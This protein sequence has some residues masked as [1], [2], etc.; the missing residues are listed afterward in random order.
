VVSKAG[1][2]I[3][4]PLPEIVDKIPA[5]DQKNIFQIFSDACSR[6]LGV[7]RTIWRGF[8]SAMALVKELERV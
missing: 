7:S 1:Q 6:S 2:Q 4:S 8:G 5:F 3:G